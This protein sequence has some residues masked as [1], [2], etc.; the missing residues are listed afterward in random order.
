MYRFTSELP[1]EE[2]DNFILNYSMAPLTQTYNWANIKSNWCHFHCGL[3]KDDTL[4]GVCLILVKKMIKGLNM[5]FVPRG[6]LI[7]FTNYEDLEEMTKNIKE[8][9][10]KTHAYVVKIDPNFCKR[11]YSFK[12]DEINT[13]K[14]YAK[15]FKLN[16]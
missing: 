7:D 10:K 3:Y 11:Q 2:Y 9:A 1:K 4:V 6:Y 15:I 14:A 8:L 13:R 12:G 16:A 5:F